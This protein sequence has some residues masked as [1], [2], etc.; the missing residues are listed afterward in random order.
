[1]VERL[2]EIVQGGHDLEACE[3]KGQHTAFPHGLAQRQ[4]RIQHHAAGRVAGLRLSG[5]PRSLLDVPQAAQLFLGL[6]QQVPVGFPQ[7][8]RR[9]PQGM[10]LTE[11]MRHVGEELSDRETDRFLRI[12][13]HPQDGQLAGGEW[14]QQVGQHRRRGLLQ[15]SSAQ[16]HAAQH[17]AHHPEL[18]VA[19]LGLQPVQR[20]DQAAVRRHR[21]CQ[22]LREI[23][24]TG[25][26]QGKVDLEQVLDVALRDL[27]LLLAE[28]LPHLRAGP[29]LLEAELADVRHDIEPVAGAFHLAGFRPGRAIDR[30]ATGGGRLATAKAQIGQMLWPNEG[31]H[32]LGPDGMAIDERRATVRAGRQ[33]GAIADVGHNAKLACSFHPG[34]PT[35]SGVAARRPAATRDGVSVPRVLLSCHSRPADARSAATGKN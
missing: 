26:Q 33:L 22:R 11:L 10:I 30:A 21:R 28:L 7:R 27:E 20:D 3:A 32:N 2:A 25:A 31:L 16:N 35:R 29:M 6:D 9:F 5:L 34:L 17:F 13:D 4:D 8:F 18:L 15:I 14:A 12:A 24:L 1:V 19:L 23:L